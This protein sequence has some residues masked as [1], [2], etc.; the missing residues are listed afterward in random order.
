MIRVLIDRRVSESTELAYQQITRDV[1]HTA[2]HMRGYISGETWRDSE[3]P[4]HY[5][6]ISTWRTRGEWDAW[7]RSPE[8]QAAIAQIAPMLLQPETVTVLEPL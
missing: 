4:H 1:R 6:L 5:V 7:A 8:R 3:N 2:M